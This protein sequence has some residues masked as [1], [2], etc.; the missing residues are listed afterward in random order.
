MWHVFGTMTE[1]SILNASWHECRTFIGIRRARPEEATLLGE[2]ALRSKGH[3]GYDAAFLANC[4]EDLA[5]SPDEVAQS[6][7][8]VAEDAEG[9][10]TGYYRLIPQGG[11]TVVLD[12]LFVEPGAIGQG[13]GRRLR[14]HAVN[15][16]SS[17][18]YTRFEFQ[19]DPHAVGF[20]QAMGVERC[21]E[22]E[23]TVTPGRALPPCASHSVESEVTTNS[24]LRGPHLFQAIHAWQPPCFIARGPRLSHR[25]KTDGRL[26]AKRQSTVGLA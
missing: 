6:P 18:G 20:Y 10:M 7:V 24:E 4:R 21:G 15:T 13:V 12:A 26:N 2:L 25:D 22:S 17:L 3:W 14:E 19:S 1:A 11:G 23:S 5:L 16:A 8:F 9:D